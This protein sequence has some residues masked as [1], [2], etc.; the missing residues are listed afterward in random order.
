MPL[1]HR[2]TTVANGMCGIHLWLTPYM[3]N[4]WNEI[5]PLKLGSIVSVWRAFSYDLQDVDI[6]I[7][8]CSASW[9]GLRVRLLT[10]R[11]LLYDE[12]N[13]LLKKIS[14][15]LISHS[16]W[17]IYSYHCITTD[18]K[19]SC[20]CIMSTK[21]IQVCYLFTL[22]DWDTFSGSFRRNKLWILQVIGS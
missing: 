19:P 2:V 21:I 14:K 5:P 13:F 4:T 1:L 17:L 22:C 16:A 9:S 3:I 7:A 6:N 8:Q 18:Y 15:A 20:V 11:L 12:L 10:L